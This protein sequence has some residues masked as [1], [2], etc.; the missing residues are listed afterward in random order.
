MKALDAAVPF[1][2]SAT[3]NCGNEVQIEDWQVGELLPDKHGVQG[4]CQG[5]DLSTG[6]AASDCTAMSRGNEIL[7]ESRVLRVISNRETLCFDVVATCSSA[8]KAKVFRRLF[9]ANQPVLCTGRFAR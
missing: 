1:A 8:N 4:I 7:N 3:F 2:I 5:Q 9:P 6:G